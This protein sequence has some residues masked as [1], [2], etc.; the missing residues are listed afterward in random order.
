MW[1]FQAPGKRDRAMG[2]FFR[3]GLAAGEHC[4]IAVDTAE[5]D[6]ILAAIGSPAEV[7][8]WEQAGRLTVRTAPGAGQAPRDLTFHQMMDVWSEVIETARST[9]VRLGGERELAAAP[10]QRGAAAALRER[11][12]P[13]HPDRIAVLCLYD[14]TRLSGDVVMDVVQTHPRALIPGF[15]VIPGFWRQRTGKFAGQLRPG[16]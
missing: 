4:M 11:D 7:A 1:T 5:P 16:W 3:T 9:R 14:L 13:R 8:G 15:R 12:E 10:D 6:D 2:A